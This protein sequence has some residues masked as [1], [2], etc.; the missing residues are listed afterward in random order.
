MIR[1][2]REQ[3]AHQPQTHSASVYTEC[4][5]VKGNRR[6]PH[7]CSKNIASD[8]LREEIQRIRAQ[9]KGV[10]IRRKKSEIRDEKS[11]LENSREMQS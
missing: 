11:R 6:K 5:G 1:C 8:V 4:I 7:T 2:P 9:T 10:R 3:G